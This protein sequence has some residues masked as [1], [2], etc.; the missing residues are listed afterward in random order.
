MTNF[1][2]AT[3]T[4][5]STGT[6]RLIELFVCTTGLHIH[7]CGN[8]STCPLAFDASA[9]GFFS[10]PIS[11]IEMQEQSMTH[12]EVVKV[13]SKYGSERWCRR[14]T[15]SNAHISNKRKPTTSSSSSSKRRSKKARNSNR[16]GLSGAQVNA[17][18][19]NSM[20]V[21]I[22][23]ASPSTAKL[24]TRTAKLV[25]QRLPFVSLITTMADTMRLYKP[26]RPCPKEYVEAIVRHANTIHKHLS[27][28]P[29]MHTLVATIASLLSC[30]LSARGVVVYP[31]LAWFTDNM[32][33]LTL[34]AQ[35]S[36][37]QCRNMSACTRAIKHA[38]FKDSGIVASLVFRC[39]SEPS[40]EH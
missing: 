28:Y 25:G 8:K 16:N 1:T 6:H 32:P 9:S 5:A 21:Q 26:T 12:S 13:T 40:A 22:A 36:H 37:L 29:S 24:V 38:V 33:P 3:S 23:C 4:H 10:C 14:Y 18:F 34:Y 2:A 15:F 19:V 39:E 20:L 11:G 35:V 27:P 17:Q 31:K 30:G 7:K